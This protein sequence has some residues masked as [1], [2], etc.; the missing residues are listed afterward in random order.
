MQ[1]LFASFVLALIVVSFSSATVLDEAGVFAVTGYSNPSLSYVTTNG[2]ITLIDALGSVANSVRV[3]EDTVYVVHSGDYTTGEGAEVWYTT[4]EN[5]EAAIAGNTSPDW[6]II[7]LPAWSNPWDVLVLEGYAF[8]TL[9]S[10]G[11]LFKIDL[12]TGE[13]VDTLTGLN[14]PEGM[15]TDGTLICVAESGWGSG[16]QA[17]LVNP[18][19]MMVDT[20]VLTGDNPQWSVVDTTG[21]FTILCSGRSWGDEPVGGSVYRYDPEDGDS[22]SFTVAGNPGQIALVYP[23]CCQGPKLVLGDEY[24]YTT[25]NISAYDAVMFVED[26]EVPD[27]LVGGNALATGLNGIFIGNAN[28][29]GDSW[30]KWCSYDWS[31]VTLLG[32]FTGEVVSLGFF[33]G[34]GGSDVAESS[35]ELP[36]TI[37]LEPAWPNPFNSTTRLSFTLSRAAD[38]RIDLYSVEGRLVRTLANGT[39]TAGTSTIAIQAE[40]LA[41]GTWFAVLTSEGRTLT[42]K[43]V[44]VR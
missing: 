2:D 38:V 43:L 28:Y 33:E 11:S 6:T 18:E 15:S 44:L 12:S 40:D 34:F 42:Q 19:T 21:V 4:L 30:I 23:E 29:A 32:T 26:T 22:T 17:V 35:K 3:F 14:A 8:V 1:R 7:E 5:I 27:T 31:E 20:I 36:S 16:A 41:S 9:T 39:Y 25:P 37:T 10:S 24:A 13:A